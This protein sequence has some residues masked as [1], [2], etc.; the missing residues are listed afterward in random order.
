MKFVINDHS[1][2]PSV[3][4]L[5]HETLKS[6]FLPEKIAAKDLQFKKIIEYSDKTNVFSVDYSLIIFKLLTQGVENMNLADTA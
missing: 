6:E 3:G 5:L 4:K 2:P 1:T